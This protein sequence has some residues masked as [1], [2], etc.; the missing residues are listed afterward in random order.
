[1]TRF[2]TIPGPV[3]PLLYS[4]LETELWHHDEIESYFQTRSED[5]GWFEEP[6]ERMSRC[7]E[8]LRIIDWPRTGP[9]LEATVEARWHDLLLEGLQEELG[10]QRNYCSPES[11]NG[12]ETCAEAE[13]DIAIIEGFLADLPALEAE[14]ASEAA[15]ERTIVLQL[16]RDDHDERW[17][18][19]ELERALGDVE[20]LTV[21]DAVERLRQ[22]GVLS[23]EGEHMWAAQ[24][25]HYLAALDMVCV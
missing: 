9:P 10:M 7:A 15:V 21:S 3:V 25:V 11:G 14:A 16:T 5:P 20:A 17:G 12:P 1:M 2:I 22:G 6:L 23:V 18:R 4:G 8:L 19:A 13:R 24:P